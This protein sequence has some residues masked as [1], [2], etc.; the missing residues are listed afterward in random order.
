M[1]ELDWGEPDEKREMAAK[2]TEALFHPMR[3]DLEQETMIPESQAPWPAAKAELMRYM[4]FF[5]SEFE[6]ALVQPASENHANGTKMEHQLEICLKEAEAAAKGDMDHLRYYNTASST[7]Y[8]AT[9]SR[10]EDDQVAV[11][12]QDLPE[13][14]VLAYNEVEAIKESEKAIA[15]ALESRLTNGEDIPVPSITMQHQASVQVGGPSRQNR[16]AG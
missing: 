13:C 6:T 12:F 16:R 1:E 10:T 4:E 8:P 11:I 9:M 14:N 7:T 5:Q 2:A 3:Y 15:H